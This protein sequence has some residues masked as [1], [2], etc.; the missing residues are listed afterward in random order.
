MKI[1]F[2]FLIMPIILLFILFG[3]NSTTI[4]TAGKPEADSLSAIRLAFAG[5]IMCHTPQMDYAKVGRDSFDFKPVFRE[6]KNFLSIPDFTFGNLETV[7]I[8]NEK[9]FSGYPLFSSPE[10]LLSALKD[11]GFDLLFTSNNHSI[12][13]G[14]NGVLKTLENLRAENLLSTGTFDS[15]R[16]RDS[17]R[18]IDIK[19]I[20]LGILSYTYG[21]NGNYLPEDSKYIVNVIDTN[22]IKSDIAKIKER[23]YDAI[24]VYYHFGDE[25]SRKP[26]SFQKE[27]AAK[28]FE[29]GA[30]IIIAS[31]PHVIQ[32]IEFF[33]KKNGKLKKGLI[34]YSIGNFISNQRR[35]YTDSGVILNLD[36]M[37][38]TKKDSL[39]INDV[40]IIPTWVYKGRTEKENE[41]VILPSDTAM[42]G[43]LPEYLTPADKQKMIQSFNDTKSMF[44]ISR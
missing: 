29:W 31:H 27:I 26:S 36:L 22:L 12:D 43:K 33:E 10:E 32:P 42:F 24:I 3:I 20:K 13:K 11:T 7:I 28:S 6:V 44:K 19:G 30:D 21:L 17:I 25:Y 34:A 14:V 9:G 18:I 40:S 2:N 35:R 4:K 38:N 16:D 39:W 15:Q 5:D 37:K 8:G 23:D 41:F 1:K